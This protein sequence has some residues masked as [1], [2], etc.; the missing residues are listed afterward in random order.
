ML[1]V[2]LTTLLLDERATSRAPFQAN[3]V[4]ITCQAHC[5][6]AGRG[7]PPD[8][9]ASRRPHGWG[10]RTPCRGEPRLPCAGPRRSPDSPTGRTRAAQP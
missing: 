4:P 7:A 9:E 2:G 5:A 6:A 3:P 1:S 10:T 8:V